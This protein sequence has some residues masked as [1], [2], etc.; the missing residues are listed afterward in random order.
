MASQDVSLKKST[1]VGASVVSRRQRQQIAPYLFIAPFFLGFIAFQLVPIAFS[2]YLSFTEW[3]GVNNIQFV[4]LDNFVTLLSR[5][6]RFW[7][8]FKVTFIITSICTLLGAAGALALAVFLEWV[9]DWLASLLRVIF[10][11]PSV[12]SVVVITY[13]W[14]Q[15]YSTD[16]GYINTLLTSLGLPPQN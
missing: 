12:T 11:L 14:K 2:I 3:S 7:N 13:I 1:P 8:A 4:G 10:F 15:L 16:Y 5:D 9:P 6:P